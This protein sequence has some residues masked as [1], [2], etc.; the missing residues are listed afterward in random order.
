MTKNKK[1]IAL[2]GA[3]GRMG[4]AIANICKKNKD[5]Q[6]QYAFEYPDHSKI[7]KNLYTELE[8]KK[9]SLKKVLVEEQ[10]KDF[11]VDFI[12]DFSTPESAINIA[13]IASTLKIP[14]VTGT[15]GF[16]SS[17]LKNLKLLSKKIPILQSYNMSVGINVLLKI[18]VQNIDYFQSTDIEITEKH[19]KKKIDSPSGT[20]ILMANTIRT[21]SKRKSEINITS[22]RKGDSVGEH[23]LASFGDKENI[24]ITH[25]AL[26]R[27]IFAVGALV[28]GRKLIKRR[29]GFYSI[30]DLL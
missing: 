7:G 30:L 16:T 29:K 28:M 11:N 20:A 2:N 24:F 19:H 8:R 9:F 4:Q 15:T 21:S 1:T 12:V 14:L 10:I 3:L 25:E 5:F 26:D 22:I 13:T 17:Q 18:L 27:S 6:I 23:T